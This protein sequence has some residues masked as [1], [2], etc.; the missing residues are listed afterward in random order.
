MTDLVLGT[1]TF[2]D[3]VDLDR[4][5]T[6]V[7]VALGN[8]ITAIDTA[9]GYAGGRSEEMLGEILRGR[10]E[11]VTIATKAGVYPGDAGGRPLLSGKGIRSSLEASLRRLGTDRVDLFYLHQPDRSVPL[12]E[13]AGALADAVRDGLIGA[14]GV[15]NYAAWQITDVSTACVAAGAPR[16]VVAQQLYNLVARRIEAEYVEYAATHR[17]DT[18]VYNP[19]GGGLLTGR[20]S[21]DDSPDEGRF[22]SSALSQ[23]YR[24]RYWSRPL[25]EAVSSL[26][27][28]AADAGLTLPELSLRWLLSRDVVTAVLLGGSK[29]EQLLSN[30]AATQQG[31]LPQDVLDACDEVGRVLSGPMP[32]YNR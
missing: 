7:D 10:W 27:T 2:G 21:F 1:M 23:M 17:L 3:T 14:I 8:G 25:F 18:I 5:R 19:L 16:P 12:E 15:S 28:I 30:I 26:S 9:N 11:E 22:G 4:A 20:H 31:P 13:T 6:M 24:D 32:A 29:P